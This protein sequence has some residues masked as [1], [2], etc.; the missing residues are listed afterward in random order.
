MCIF[1]RWVLGD[2][3]T[4][5]DPPHVCVFELHVQQET[6]FFL[7]LDFVCFYSVLIRLDYSFLRSGKSIVFHV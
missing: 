6:F 5:E 4:R 1:F 2:L 7:N 3:W